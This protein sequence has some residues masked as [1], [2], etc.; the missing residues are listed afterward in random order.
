MENRIGQAARPLLRKEIPEFRPDPPDHPSGCQVNN[1]TLAA[2]DLSDAGHL[3]FEQQVVIL[4]FAP[5]H[6]G[7][8]TV[9][10]LGD[11]RDERSEERRVGKECRL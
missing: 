11:R 1:P 6:H 2:I 9:H 5:H 4:Q 8:L 3:R 7:L 10:G